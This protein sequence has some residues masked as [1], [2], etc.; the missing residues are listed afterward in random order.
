MVLVHKKIRFALA[1]QTYFELRARCGK[2]LVRKM[3]YNDSVA[4]KCRTVC[5]LE[6]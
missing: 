5:E 4:F 1:V 6:R 3:A 2:E